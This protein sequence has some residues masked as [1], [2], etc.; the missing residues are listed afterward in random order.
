MSLG[1]WIFPVM[2]ISLGLTLIVELAFALACRVRGGWELAL[3]AAVNVLT[4]PAVVAGYYLGRMAVPA[5]W[6]WALKLG[7]EI[8]AFAAEA[9][10]YRMCSRQIRRPWQFSAAANLLSYGSGLV[11]MYLL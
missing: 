2:G 10:C 11:F 3:V 9:L 1:T 7:L 6:L 4:N 5:A 8:S